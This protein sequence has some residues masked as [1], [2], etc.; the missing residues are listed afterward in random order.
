MNLISKLAGLGL[1]LGVLTG[2]AGLILRLTIRDGWQP[3]APFFYA[4]PLPLCLGAFVVFAI[5][6]RKRR[7][8]AISST[9]LAV[10]CLAIW[11]FHA[12]GWFGDSGDF[13]VAFWN[14]SDSW[15]HFE[16][17]FDR[18]D[19]E[20]I[21]LLLLAEAPNSK[22]DQDLARERGFEV[23]GLPRE[24]AIACRGRIL[25]L[26]THG[27]QFQSV[28]HE[29]S[30]EIDGRVCRVIFVD[31][32]PKP[33]WPRGPI[34]KRILEIAGDKPNTIIVGDF[35]TPVESVWFDSFRENFAFTGDAPGS[36]TRET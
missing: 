15:E 3:L 34:L 8:L 12:P 22:K 28:A 24:M 17:A 27:L 9:M 21:D 32:G 2:C 31:V 16:V 1:W 25:E 33:S 20:S 11:L 19:E 4:T 6:N 5:R 30:C 18:L 35:N 7:R 23:R 26:T 29:I 10:V 14:A 13:R 36:G